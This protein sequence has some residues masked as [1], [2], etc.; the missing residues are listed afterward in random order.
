MDLSFTKSEEWIAKRE[1]FWVD[2]S[3]DYLPGTTRKE[4]KAIHKYFMTGDFPVD[5]ALLSP[6]QMI[7]F[8]PV[9]SSE[10][11]SYVLKNYFSQDSYGKFTDDD[12]R[13]IQDF[14]MDYI[15]LMPWFDVDT[16]VELFQRV[17]G[18]SYDENRIFPFLIGDEADYRKIALSAEE[19]YN[20][21]SRCLSA[22]LR[23]R[24]DNYGQMWSRMAN[25][26]Y[27]LFSRV[28]EDC[29]AR[30]SKEER[31]VGGDPL[32]RVQK[33]LKSIM[34][35]SLEYKY[36]WYPISE[37][38]L[39]RIEFMLDFRKRIENIDYYPGELLP[40]WDSTKE[41][42]RSKIMS[43]IH[44]DFPESLR[45]NLKKLLT[46]VLMH[47]VNEALDFYEVLC[48]FHSQVLA[49]LIAKEKDGS[50]IIYFRVVDGVTFL[51]NSAGLDGEVYVDGWCEVMSAIEGV[52]VKKHVY[53]YENC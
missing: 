28:G 16:R 49:D 10:G 52:N 48:G 27:S 38:H 23:G 46:H 18:E 30:E 20:N 39:G 53:K 15:E 29:F 41:E 40:M 11:A 4:L 35:L 50:C 25:Y 3:A 13:E 26:W 51:E 47:E 44:L 6:A 43:I 21:A 37:E 14:F 1:A 12:C 42:R 45:G 34:T 22:W 7:G 36:H 24:T 19:Q 32:S 8:F 9:C 5:K 2:F 31:K 33:R 17:F